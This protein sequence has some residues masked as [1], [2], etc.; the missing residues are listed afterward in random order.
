[1][2][3]VA[4]AIVCKT[5]TAGKSKTRLSPP[6]RPD[7][8]ATISGCFICDVSA[9]IQSLAEEGDVAGYAIYT[10][11]GSQAALRCLLPG[12][13][14]LILQGDGDLGARLLKATTDL[15]A[16]GFAGAI[17]VNSDA[18]TLPQA[19]LRAAADAVRQGDNVVLSPAFDGGYTLIGLSRQ[20]AR[21]F[22]NIPWSTREVYRQTLQRAQEIGLP[23]VDVPGWYD[24]DDA[25]SFRMLEDELN[26]RRP[27][28]AAPHLVAA[29]APATRQFIRQ[30]RGD[31]L[32]PA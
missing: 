18:P 9:T 22:E 15:L 10:P 25:D 32:M 16:A 14:R 26:G 17:L 8:C 11:L 2:S 27:S 7:E 3:P 1:M 31:V 6:L 28:F 30:R 21:L 4:V 19:I 23:V 29:E 12:A 20:H 5:P 24:V 13:F